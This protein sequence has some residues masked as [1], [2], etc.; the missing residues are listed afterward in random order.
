MILNTP[1]AIAA[2]RMIA[3]APDPSRTLERTDLEGLSWRSVGPANSKRGVARLNS[4]SEFGR[5]WT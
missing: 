2:L 3:A 5:G 4:R 1:A